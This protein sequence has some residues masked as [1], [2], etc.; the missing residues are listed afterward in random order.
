M[1][2]ILIVNDQVL[3]RQIIHFALRQLPDVLI[4]GEAE[5]GL[6]AIECVREMQPDVVVMDF[7]M[8]IMNGLEATEKITATWPE[9]KVI[10][11]SMSGVPEQAGLTVGAFMV[12]QPYHSMKMLQTAVLNA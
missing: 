1:K 10:I 6:K 9:I 2:R 8:P 5:N 12:L 4:I 7:R 11:H 3:S